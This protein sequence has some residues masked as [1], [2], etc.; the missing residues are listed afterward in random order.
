MRLGTHLGITWGHTYWPIALTVASIVLGLLFFPAEIYA[1]FTNTSNTL[2]DFSRYE[3]GVT[4]AFGAQTIIHTV[5]WWVSFLVWCG[6]VFVI[7]LHIWFDM[8]G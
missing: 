6:F 5:A 8:I 1:M 7:T 3:L 4:T 2:S